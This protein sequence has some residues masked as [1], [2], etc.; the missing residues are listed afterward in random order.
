[1]SAYLKTEN[2]RKLYS[3]TIK[4]LYE[5]NQTISLE[6]ILEILEDAITNAWDEGYDFGA[7]Y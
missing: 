3:E 1:M 2:L 5:K 4:E 6:D 7:R